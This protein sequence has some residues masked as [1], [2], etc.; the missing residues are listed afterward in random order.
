[1]FDELKKYS[2]NDHFFFAPDESL[3]DS[4]NAPKNGSGV[5]V[6]NA[7]SQGGIEIIYIGSSGKIHNDGNL[8]QRSGGLHDRIVNGKQFNGP[9][10]R[11]WPLKMREEK[12]D[13]LIF[14]GMKPSTNQFS[15]YRSTLKG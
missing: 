13:A 15:I 4:C 1:M 8:K 6:I 11:I 10:R 5:Y 9:R 12:I 14:I 2:T 7:L 3:K